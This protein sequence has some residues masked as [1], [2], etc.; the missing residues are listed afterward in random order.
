[1]IRADKARRQQR[2]LKMVVES[3]QIVHQRVRRLFMLNRRLR[4][5]LRRQPGH[6]HFIGDNL[7]RH[8]QVQRAVLRVGG[9]RHVIVALLQFI[10]GQTNAL[11]AKD[12][13]HR[14]MLTFGDAFQTAFARVEHRPRQRA[15][16]RAGANHQATACQRFIKGIDNLRVA[17]HVAG[18]RGQG[19]RLRIGFDQRIDQPQVS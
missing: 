7:H 13:R 2:L 19:Y 6:P 12:Q 4:L 15:G 5:L 3:L 14:R 17:D 10:V 16:A 11:A 8:R 18:A 1:M 9:D